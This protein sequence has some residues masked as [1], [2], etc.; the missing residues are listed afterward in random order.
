MGEISSSKKRKILAFNNRLG[1]IPNN[2]TSPN[3]SKGGELCVDV[4]LNTN[5]KSPPRGDLE[6]SKREK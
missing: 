5:P 2:L 3:P 4:D 6:G 1:A